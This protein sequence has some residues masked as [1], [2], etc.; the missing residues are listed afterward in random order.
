MMLLRR[1]DELSQTISNGC[2]QSD[3]TSLGAV[4]RCER[5]SLS[6]IR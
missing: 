5:R 1:E 2:R 4:R 3:A 6:A